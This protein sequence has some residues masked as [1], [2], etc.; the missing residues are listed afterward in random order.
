LADVQAKRADNDGGWKEILRCYFPQA[1]QFFFP[2]TSA[3]VDWS[4]PIEFLDTQLQQITK[5]A[6]VGRRIADLLV[7]VFIT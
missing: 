7:K 5:E 6:E 4:Q 1:I 3:L 2:E